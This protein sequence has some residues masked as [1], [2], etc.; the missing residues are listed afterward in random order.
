[1]GGFKIV[2][3]AT[4]T[5][6]SALEESTGLQLFGVVGNSLFYKCELVIDYIF[7]EVTIY[8]LDRKGMRKKDKKNHRCPDDTLKFYLKGKMPIIAAM[9]GQECL[10]LGLDS[11]ASS[12]VIDQH[13]QE[14]LG[15]HFS[16][17]SK[18]LLT[19][20]GSE[21]TEVTAS[22]LNNLLV[23]RLNC[24]P[25]KT[26]FVS[27]NHFNRHVKGQRLDGILGYEFL[28]QF[29]VS[30]NFKKQ[31]IYLWE[32]PTVEAQWL[33]EKSARREQVAY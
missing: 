27:M 12:C 8:R 3:Q 23:G 9:A 1:L 29:R 24:P 20:F 10:M 17:F 2:T 15:G 11:G 25:M 7:H 26:I 6:F 13:F 5:N 33:A 21:R 4:I 32:G 19:S 18:T 28:S 30:I 31:E 14:K 22:E 16:D